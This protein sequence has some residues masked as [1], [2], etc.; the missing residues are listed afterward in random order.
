MVK[1]RHSSARASNGSRGSSARWAW[2]RRRSSSARRS[3]RSGRIGGSKNALLL[4]GAGSAR[5][6]WV[7]PSSAP[8]ARHSSAVRVAARPVLA[9][10]Q[11]K[12][13]RG[14]RPIVRKVCPCSVGERRG[15]GEA[16]RLERCEQAVL[17]AGGR[18]THADVVLEE[19]PAARRLHD[20]VV[21]QV[22]ASD[23]GEPHDLAEAVR[24]A[25]P[26]YGS[27]AEAALSGESRM[28]HARRS[29]RWQD[30]RFV[31][32]YTGID[33]KRGREERD[34]WQQSRRRTSISSLTTAAC[35]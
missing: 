11:G 8:T 19:V 1:S 15:D 20:V 2:I 18:P 27:G 9:A 7:R 4:A 21:V 5:A 25:D 6:R 14:R 23:R 22:A 34:A 13:A 35:P 26:A 28:R 31:M 17:T 10:I 24:L 30:R 12:T 29:P 16:R 33:A 32:I 3:V